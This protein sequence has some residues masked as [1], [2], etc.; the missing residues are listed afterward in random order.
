MEEKTCVNTM[1]VKPAV[2]THM[3]SGTLL[4][5]VPRLA[6]AVP[7]MALGE[8]LLLSSDGWGN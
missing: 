7:A 5:A 8:V 1:R 4:V 2:G 3:G 6:R